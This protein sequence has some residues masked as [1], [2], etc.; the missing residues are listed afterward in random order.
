M[1]EHDPDPDARIL[2]SMVEKIREKVRKGE[3]EAKYLA[4][5]EYM[6]NPD[7]P[8]PVKDGDL[9]AFYESMRQDYVLRLK[10]G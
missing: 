2:L 8:L 5:A 10:N 4:I 7:A 9:P 3:L 1:I 6:T